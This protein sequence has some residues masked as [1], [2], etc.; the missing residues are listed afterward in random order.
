RVGDDEAE[1]DRPQYV[2][3]IRQRQMVRPA[4]RGDRLLGELARVADHTQ[5][6]N[7]R[8]EVRRPARRRRRRARNVDN[9]RRSGHQGTPATNP[10]STSTTASAAT[11]TAHQSRESV[12]TATFTGKDPERVKPRGSCQLRGRTR[13][14]RVASSV[15]GGAPASKVTVAPTDRS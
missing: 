1:D 4:V 6:D 14:T 2:L 12:M 5:E 3:D 8:D 11:S 13:R 15:L 9:S 10:S 7:A